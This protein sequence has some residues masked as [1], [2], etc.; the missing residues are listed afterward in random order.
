MSLQLSPL[1]VHACNKPWGRMT[2]MTSLTIS[3]SSRQVVRHEHAPHSQHCALLT[4]ELT[5]AFVLSDGEASPVI[6]PGEVATRR[7]APHNAILGTV[8]THKNTTTVCLDRKQFEKHFSLA[9]VALLIACLPGGA[10]SLR[11]LLGAR[12]RQAERA[13]KIDPQQDGAAQARALV[14]RELS[15]TR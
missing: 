12:W 6:R 9:L 15:R 13:R 8:Q 1:P 3:H 14:R 2:N 11:A 7:P 5:G 4:W 10:S